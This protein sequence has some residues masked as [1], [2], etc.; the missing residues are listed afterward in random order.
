MLV[1]KTRLMMFYKNHSC[2]M[3]IFSI[4]TEWSS[5]NHYFEHSQTSFFNVIRFFFPQLPKM[6]IWV[7]KMLNSK[8]LVDTPIFNTPKFS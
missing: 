8:S 5:S 1:E 7:V 6:L 2:K 3:P 4:F